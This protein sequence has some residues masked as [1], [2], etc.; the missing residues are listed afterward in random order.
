[1]IGGGKQARI[2]L[3]DRDNLGQFNAVTD[4]VVQELDIASIPG[5]TFPTIPPN[6]SSGFGVPGIFSTP[7]YFNGTVYYKPAAPDFSVN[8]ATPLLAFP[9]TGGMLSTTPSMSGPTWG[10]PGSSPSISANGAADGI[11]WAL[12]CDPTK[13]AVLHAFKASDITTELYNSFLAGETLSNAVKFS[14]PTIA[15]GRVYVG[16]SNNLTIFG[17]K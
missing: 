12:E 14:V 4:Q 16:T 7:A 11:V 17:L 6:P 9:L 13:P 1:M 3:V 15:N 10:W 8:V 5:L 2:Y